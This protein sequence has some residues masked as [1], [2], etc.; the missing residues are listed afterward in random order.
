MPYLDNL[1]GWTESSP[2]W[3]PYPRNGTFEPGYLKLT[4]E[5]V[6]ERM[7]DPH[8]EYKYM[9]ESYDTWYKMSSVWNDKNNIYIPKVVLKT[10]PKPSH[11]KNNGK[12]V[13]PS[14]TSSSA[15]KLSPPPYPLASKLATP[16]VLTSVLAAPK[17]YPSLEGLS[18]N[19]DGY[20]KS[21]EE[22]LDIGSER[23]VAAVWV[24][25]AR[26]GV[27][28]QPPSP[29]ALR[30]L[31]DM[32]TSVSDPVNFV[33]MLMRCSRHCQLVGADYRFILQNIRR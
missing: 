10:V 16:S 14:I 17:L 8:W 22:G 9:R 7:G 5:L 12:G 25:K 32:L 4:Y 24:A 20:H 1:A 2:Q 31:I 6:Y 27:E 26:G 19:K 21:P 28:I 30:D 15:E 29:S 11:C 23:N 33:E 18:K 3:R 13:D